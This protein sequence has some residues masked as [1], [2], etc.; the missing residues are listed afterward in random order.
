MSTGRPR[1]ALL[2][3]AGVLVGIL[4]VGGLYLLQSKRK[5]PIAAPATRPSP[6]ATA[7]ASQPVVTGPAT[8]TELVRRHYPRYPTTQPLDVPLP[9]NYAGQFIIPDRIY[10]DGDGFLWVTRDDVEPAESRL[11]GSDWGDC[12]FTA[13]RP[14]F[15]YWQEDRR[16]RFP[17]IIRLR[18]SGDGYELVNYLGRTAIGGGTDYDW[19]RAFAWDNRLVVPMGAGVCVFTVGRHIDQSTSPPLAEAGAAHAPVQV[20]FINGPLAWIPP[21]K[22]HPGSAGIVRYIDGAWFRLGVEQGWPGGIVHLLPMLDH[23]VLQLLAKGDEM[24]LAMVSLDPPPADLRQ[25]L[26]PLIDQLGHPDPRKRQEAQTKLTQYGPALWAVADE[27]LSRK[28]G[29]PEVLGRL[30]D[31]LRGKAAPMLGGMHAADNKLRLL[32]RFVDGGALFYADSVSVPQGDDPP[33]VVAPAWLAARPGRPVAL[34]PNDLVQDL[35]PDACRLMPWGDDEWVLSDAVL[36]PRILKGPVGKPV[37]LVRKEHREFRHFVGKDRQGGYL[38]RRNP[39]DESPTLVVDPSLPD[40]A[41]RLPVWVRSYRETGWDKDDFP[42]VRDN[43]AWA[44]GQSAWR[45]I[46]AKEPFHTKLASGPATKP[47]VL[48]VA[49]D[50]T[51]YL[52]GRTELIIEAKGREPI[53]CPLTDS[54]CGRDDYEPW[55]VKA[56]GFLFLFNQPGRVL[57]LRPPEQSGQVDVDAVFAGK[58]PNSSHPRRI[59]LD[60]LGRICIVCDASTLAILFPQG[61][62]PSSTANLIPAGDQEEP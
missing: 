11:P 17:S 61:Y 45:A 30:R 23:S 5:P 59:W 22:D 26:L 25:T 7:P 28:A 16:K 34:L 19:S 54:A 37:A 20:A 56:D 2:A 14:V 42:A 40:P 21:G 38:L 58:I 33:E 13:D 44:L 60:A 31:V 46:D 4:L 52:D 51:R 62:I 29:S 27:I 15:V 55:L 36:G 53:V 1:I 50:G 8:F 18:K 41:P 9:L 35:K 6:P 3:L 32:D 24:R 47:K 49:T 48:L 39:T 57:R 10:L 43:S 12:L